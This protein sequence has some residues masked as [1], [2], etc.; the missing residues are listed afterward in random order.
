M[1]KKQIILVLFSRWE[2]FLLL[3]VLIGVIADRDHTDQLDI[4]TPM[5]V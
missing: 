4:C 5:L 1:D 2:L 3:H